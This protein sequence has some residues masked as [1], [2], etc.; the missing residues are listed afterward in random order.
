MEQ[1]TPFWPNHLK[2]P[3][4][5]LNRH[6]LQKQVE[7]I[8]KT[9]FK[10]MQAAQIKTKPSKPKPG[11]NKSKLTKYTTNTSIQRSPRQT[12]NRTSLLQYEGNS[13]QLVP[14]ADNE[15]S[16][17]QTSQDQKINKIKYLLISCER[18]KLPLNLWQINTNATL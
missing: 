4:H 13:F 2:Q 3:V 12:D 14:G 1:K 10:Q 5:G 6:S 16:D 15:F 18:N 9:D 7:T 8:A 17:R 11:E